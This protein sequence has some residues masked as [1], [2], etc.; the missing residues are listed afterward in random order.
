M[1]FDTCRYNKPGLQM[2]ASLIAKCVL[3][4]ILLE[5]L[6]YKILCCH[7]FGFF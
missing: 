6:D 5:Q 7:C 1:T 3:I 2:L 4:Y